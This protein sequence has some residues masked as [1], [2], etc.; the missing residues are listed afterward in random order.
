MGHLNILSVVFTPLIL[1]LGIDYG[2]HVLSRYEE[3]LARR[4]SV[5]EALAQALQAVGPGI[6]NAAVTAAA[7]FLALA[8][9]DFQGL[10]ELGL[11][12]GIGILLCLAATLLVLPALVLVVDRND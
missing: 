5:R 3:A 9:T 6:I 12:S 1:G 4:F 11:I 10:R 2:I 8:L 7:S